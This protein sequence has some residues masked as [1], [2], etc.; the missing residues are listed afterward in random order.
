MSSSRDPNQAQQTQADSTLLA[1][2]CG[3]PPHPAQFWLPKQRHWGLDRIGSV[4]FIY[5]YFYF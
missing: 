5:L 2:I 1:S 3:D 4:L